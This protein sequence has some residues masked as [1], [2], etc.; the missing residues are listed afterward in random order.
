MRNRRFVRRKGSDSYLVKSSPIKNFTISGDGEFLVAVVSGEKEL[1]K[2]RIGAK[3]LE[4][5]AR[6][7]VDFSKAYDGFFRDILVDRDCRYLLIPD[8]VHIGIY[9]LGSLKYVKRFLIKES[10]DETA[11]VM[12]LKFSFDNKILAVADDLETVYIFRWP[13]LS[14]IAETEGG[15]RTSIAFSSRDYKL[16]IGCGFQGGAHIDLKEW[17][18]DC[19][20]EWYSFERSEKNFV[21]CISSLEISSDSRW[22]ASY[23][24]SA[25]YHEDYPPGWRGN[26]AVHSLETGELAWETYIDA[27]LGGDRRPLAEA[28]HFLGYFTQICIY[29]DYYVVCG[30]TKGKIFVFELETGD[31]VCSFT[32]PA[33]VDIEKLGTNPRGDG[34]LYVLG[35]ELLFLLPFEEILCRA[36]KT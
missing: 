28:G 32:L 14:C 34:V 35:G 19:F 6:M 3:E 7:P 23:E 2:Y 9:E 17:D 30:S 22:L 12:A 33:E 18:G 1:L 16:A 27:K 20:H 25:V 8:G 26:L 21:D 10:K 24:T 36:D 15:E 31:L 5:V 13:D 29:R 11:G 4:L